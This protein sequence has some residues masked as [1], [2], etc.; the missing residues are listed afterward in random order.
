MLRILFFICL[1]SHDS[2]ELGFYLNSPGLNR[3]NPTPGA[4][5]PRSAVTLHP[6]P[7]DWRARAHSVSKRTKISIWAIRITNPPQ[8]ILKSRFKRLV[9][10]FSVKHAWCD[11]LF[12]IKTTQELVGNVCSW[13]SIFFF[14]VI[15]EQLQKEQFK[16]LTCLPPQ[17]RREYYW[18]SQLFPC[19]YPTISHT[20]IIPWDLLWG[21]KK[22]PYSSDLVAYLTRSLY[23]KKKKMWVQKSWKCA[24]AAS[25]GI[26]ACPSWRASAFSGSLLKLLFGKWT[27]AGWVQ[28]QKPEGFCVNTHRPHQSLWK[29]E[30]GVFHQS[31]WLIQEDS[32]ALP[33]HAEASSRQGLELPQTPAEDKIYI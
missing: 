2:P 7:S 30:R 20:K 29:E 22:S 26:P 23:L 27:W 14:L 24:H 3:R 21:G 9:L 13:S 25:P 31:G 19:W 11:F 5:W 16:F 17:N 10:R 6:Q 4:S 15:W 33:S 1:N 12:R 32:N 8:R 28:N 18:F